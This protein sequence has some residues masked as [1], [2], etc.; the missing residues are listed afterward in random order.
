MSLNIKDSSPRQITSCGF[1]GNRSRYHSGKLPPAAHVSYKPEMVGTQYGWVRIINPEKRWS[2]NWNYC[3]AE[4]RCTGCGKIEWINLGSLT[5]GRSKGCQNCSEKDLPHI[6]RWLDR[7]LT[8]AKQR[9][10]NPNDG[11]WESYGGRGI[12]FR[13]SSIQEAGLWIVDNLPNVSEELELDRIDTNG[14][15]EPG[16][17]R[18]VDRKANIG[19]RRNTVLSRFEQRYWPYEQSVVRRKLSTGKSRSQIINDARTA[20]KHRYK[21][22]PLIEARLEFMTYDMPESITVTPYRDISSTTADTKAASAH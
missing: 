11:Q 9:C 13:F 2:K 15:Y 14:H 8:S 6:P 12:E 4:T 16:N 10:T 19:N 5:S 22:W 21:A 3:Y 1:K 17:L 20:V 7:R 18:F